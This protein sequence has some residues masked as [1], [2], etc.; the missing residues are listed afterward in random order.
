L[1]AIATGQSLGTAVASAIGLPL[2]NL[3]GFYLSFEPE[4]AVTCRAKYYVDA[5]DGSLL[6][7]MMER[8]FKL[9]EQ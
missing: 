6:P 7:Q 8:R 2:K 9:V 5:D 3:A 1:T 4:N